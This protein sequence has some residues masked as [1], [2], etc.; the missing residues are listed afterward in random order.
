[1]QNYVGEIAALLAAL[2]WTISAL[3]WT[4][5][6]KQ[7]GSMVV[8][9]V[10]LA[11]SLPL[12]VIY[13]ALVLGEVIPLSASP[14]E[15]LILGSSGVIG[16]F[17]C[18]L[19]LFRS[20]LLIGPRLAMLIFSL[21][22][23]VTSL[24]GWWWL[25]EQL[26]RTDMTGMAIALSGVSWVVLES[27]RQPNPAIAR[28]HTSRL[29]LLFAFLAML[30]QAISSVIAKSGMQE[31]AS[32]VAATEIRLIAGLICFI[33]LMPTVGK[34]KA[35]L[36]VFKRPQVL[37]IMIVG[38]IAGPTLGVALLMFSFKHI[39]TGLAM[40]FVSLTPVMIIPFSVLI[41]K[42][43]VSLRAILG[44]ILACAGAAMLLLL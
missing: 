43:H 42:E 7:V 4:T 28:D 17:I 44:A 30:A 19:V 8:N 15:W 1:M 37:K 32:P 2:G 10:R 16:F 26:S 11:I 18:D 25:G 12:F 21:S 38:S 29:G 5:A 14:R 35:C 39:S 40:T 33:I 13:G 20:F 27:P 31:M 9:T 3:C 24:C 34:S 23:I 22:P 36:D 41:Y 6:G